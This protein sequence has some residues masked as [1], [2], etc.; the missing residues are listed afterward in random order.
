[1]EHTRSVPRA[2]PHCSACMQFTDCVLTRDCDA[3]WLP[4][5]EHTQQYDHGDCSGSWYVP[6]SE[7]KVGAKIH[8][9]LPVFARYVPVSARY[10][11]VSARYV[12][13]SARYVPVSARY[14]PRVC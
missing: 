3:I 5:R 12:P 4:C 11:P 1:M 8:H 7:R 2:H 9:K 6:L 14:V 13:V 10:V